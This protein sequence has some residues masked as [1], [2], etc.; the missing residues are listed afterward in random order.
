MAYV[1][2]MNNTPQ[3]APPP[4]RVM[5][6]TRSPPAFVP[7]SSGS[8]AGV[9]MPAMPKAAAPAPAQ[10]KPMAPAAAPPP[11]PAAP[12]APSNPDDDFQIERF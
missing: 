10:A 4:Q 11:K 6:P 12:V 3:Q 1:Q 8:Q 7:S 2:Q 9:P 5:T